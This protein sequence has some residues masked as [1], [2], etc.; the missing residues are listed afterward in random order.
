MSTDA[1]VPDHEVRHPQFAAPS[2]VARATGLAAEDFARDYWSVRP[3]LRTSAELS[4]DGF[5]D[6]LDATAVDELIS[7]RG[8]R[9]PFLRMAKEG[10]VLAPARY[11]RG[12]GVGATITDQVA[13]D[14]V[15][16][17]IADGATL[18]LQAL[19]RTWPPL[20]QFASALSAELGHPVQINAYITPPQNQG[21]AAHYDTHDVFVLQVAGRKHWR[22]HEPVLADPLVDQPWEKHRAAVAARAEQAPLIDT[23]LA[24]GDALYL[25]RGYLH[26]AVALGELSIHLTVGIHPITRTALV[27]ELLAAAKTDPR[28][29]GS[30][31]AA[32]DLADPAT[33]APHLRDTLVALTDLLDSG[34]DEL[35]ARVA[36][37]LGATLAAGTRP[38]PIAPLAQAELLAA[39][40]P[41]TALRLRAGLRYTL[42]SDDTGVHLRVLDKTVT[43]PA[44]AET[45]LK[46]VLSG[47]TFRP[48]DLPGLD[49]DEQLVLA[50]RLLREAVI[51][52]AS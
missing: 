41:D 29:R 34:G 5:A 9:T 43:M 46:T 14:K 1:G 8:L 42:S 12:G 38:E 2:A 37:G 13:D 27:T 23:D 32:V 30:L 31:P 36:A 18:V 50:R 35:T 22:I 48:A 49:A 52:P 4:A 45:A 6:L 33:L 47:A 7:C 44:T 39:M 25:P 40:T 28:L 15:L 11:T 20:V 10:G 24:P 51:V 3:L 19:H 21:F 26:S 16:N 17:L